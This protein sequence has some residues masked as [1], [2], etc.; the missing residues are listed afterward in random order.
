MA[1]GPSP[2]R[3]NNLAFK[4]RCHEHERVDMAVTFSLGLALVSRALSGF[5][6]ILCLPF[7]VESVQSAGLAIL[8]DLFDA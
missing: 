3:K 5:Y 6:S 2:L 7:S 1:L 8:N 4:A